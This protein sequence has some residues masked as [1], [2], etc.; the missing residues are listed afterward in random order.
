MLA[1]V[2]AQHD[3]FVRELQNYT[4]RKAKNKVQCSLCSSPYEARQQDKSEVLFKPQQYSNKTRLDTSTVVR[5]IC[6][7]CALELML[8][9][10]LQNMR[11]GT[12]QDEKPITLWLYPTYFFTAETARIMH[13]FINQLRDLSLLRM[14]FS[15]LERHGFELAALA[16]IRHLCVQRFR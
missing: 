1:P 12:A 4:E 13:Q 8:R 9:Q 10:V 3:R 14:I 5:G 16:S 7:I 15:H 2:K 11:P 6:P